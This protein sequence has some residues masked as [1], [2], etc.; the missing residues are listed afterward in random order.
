MA[1]TWTITALKYDNDSDKGV[2]EV[3]WECSDKETVSGVD[4]EGIVVG[5]EKFTPNPSD[6]GYIAYESLTHVK[7]RNWVKTLLG[8]DKVTGVETKVAAQ[9]TKSKTP[10]ILNTTNT[11][12]PW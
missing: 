1:A 9:I 11:G 12:L 5:S 10:P 8:S 6:S 2:V 4:H 7:V 3:S